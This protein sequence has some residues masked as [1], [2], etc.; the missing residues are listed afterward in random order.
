[1]R[2]PS[3]FLS[4]GAP[5][6]LLEENATTQFWQSLPG[7]LPEKPRAVLCVS[8]HW[9]APQLRISGTLGKT[10][11]LHDYYGFPKALYDL[12]WDEHEDN[13]TSAW[14]LGRLH[15]LHVDVREDIRPKDHGLWVPLKSA[16]PAPDFPVYQLSLNL[17]Q[18]L[19]YHWILGQRLQALRDEGVL[20]IGSGGI[21]HNLQAIEWHA[22]EGSAAPWAS[23]FVDALERA[24]ADSDCPALCRPWQFGGRECHPTLEHY[25]PLLVTLGAAGGE[26]VQ[27]LHRSWRYGTIALNA[28]GAGIHLM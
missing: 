16:W 3:L 24:M 22:P 17:T 23:S 14:L 13:E 28:Y 5:S 8:A 9:D 12:T 18:G 19:E 6:F 25:A 20:I 7:L 1:M 4:H 10:G 27:T 11:I 2:Q 26:P 21:T 15:D